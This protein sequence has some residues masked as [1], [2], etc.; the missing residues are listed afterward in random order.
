MPGC[1]V[2]GNGWPFGRVALFACLTAT[3]TD[4]SVNPGDGGP[5]TGWVRG[6]VEALAEQARNLVEKFTDLIEERLLS[7]RETVIVARYFS[8]GFT[9]TAPPFPGGQ[10][11][12]ANLLLGQCRKKNEPAYHR[13]RCLRHVT[14]LAQGWE[15][16]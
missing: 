9:D 5:F 12:V 15:N 8:A 13:L 11:K 10:V 4:F 16:E 14:L 2:G 7:R 6:Q 1:D 3:R